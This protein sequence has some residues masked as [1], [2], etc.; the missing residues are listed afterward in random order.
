[1]RCTDCH[2]TAHNYDYL[3]GRPAE[4]AG[5]CLPCFWARV[6]ALTRAIDEHTGTLEGLD[7]LYYRGMAQFGGAEAAAALADIEMGDAVESGEIDTPD[8]PV[9]L[10]R[11]LD[12]FSGN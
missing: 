10:R 6:D 1:M 3:K 4:G 7:E 2:K 11:L 8:F 5:V 9:T 12:K